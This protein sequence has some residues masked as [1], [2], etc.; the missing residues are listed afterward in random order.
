MKPRNKKE[1][2]NMNSPTPL[3]RLRSHIS[4]IVQP[5]PR[6]TRAPTPKSV[7]YVRGTIGLALSAYDA[8]VIDHAARAFNFTSAPCIEKGRTTRV[9]KQ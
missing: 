3:S 1:Q 5:A 8:I 4:L 2:R 7:M 6:M 9:E